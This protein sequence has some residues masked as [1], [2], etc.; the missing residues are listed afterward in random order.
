MKNFIKNNVVKIVCGL[1]MIC[2]V[3]LLLLLKPQKS[4]KHVKNYYN[5]S[6]E[7]V[8][9]P[10]TVVIKNDSMSREHCSNNICIKDVEF[11]YDSVQG[12]F[13]Y[14]VINKTNVVQSGYLKLVF[15]EKSF[16][17]VYSDVLPGKEKLNTSYFN[18]DNLK[19]TDDY[20][21]EELSEEDKSR[22]IK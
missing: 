18:I 3:V 12:R 1:L 17:V 7:V 5:F 20:I 10:N 19:L 16:I 2:L 8:E 21:L 4:T 13:N 9:T 14:T 11:Y 6:D 22:I 15:G